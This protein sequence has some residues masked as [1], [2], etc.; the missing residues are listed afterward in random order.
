MT[1]TPPPT[2]SVP[3]EWAGER[4]YVV[5]GGESI[6]AQRKLI[7]R[8][9]GR[10]IAI[11]QGVVLKPDA[12]VLFLSG[13]RTAQIAKPLLPKFTG[14]HVIVRGKSC[15]E[16]PETVKRVAR[17]KDHTRLSDLPDHV[18]GYDAG[19]SAIN[20]AFHFG[21]TEIVMLGYDMCGGRWFHGEMPHHMPK[22]PEAHFHRH[23]APLPELAKDC[24]RRGIRVVNVSPISRV[25]AFER[26]RLEDWL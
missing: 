25:T 11:K 6:R 22:P 21:A 17:S 13:E 23:M 14:T 24:Q 10:V 4:C 15:P 7:P 12:D 3:R 5:C 18:C 19:T 1:W 8:L 26:G 9:P 16:L 2:W 20:L